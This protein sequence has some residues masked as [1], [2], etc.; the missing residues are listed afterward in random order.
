MENIYKILSVNIADKRGRKF[1]AD[2]I[3]LNQNGVEGDVHAG[4]IR[5]VSLLGLGHVDHFRGLTGSREFEFGEFAENISIEGMGDLEPKVFDRYISEDVELEVTAAGKP[6]HDKFREPGNYVMPKVGIFCRVIK[7]GI[8]KAGDKLIHVPKTYRINV[9]T[10]SDRAS[11]GIYEDRSGPAIIEILEQYFSKIGERLEIEHTIIPDD[12]YAL[13]TLLW[14]AE[15][16]KMD[17]VIT[18][19]GTGIGSRDFTPEVVQSVLDTEIPGI[20]EMIRM[21]YGVEKPNAILS[22]GVAGVMGDSLV[23][24]LPGSVKAVKEY[25]TEIMKTLRHLIY[26][27]HDVDVH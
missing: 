10:L 6:F 18:T 27:L 20:M 9:I 22:R 16:E 4:T 2:E 19:G 8:L 1:P 26:M 3:K 13:E 11:K 24:A 23:Y 12:P 5:Q 17:V 7:P 21:K 15:D 14:K 25:M